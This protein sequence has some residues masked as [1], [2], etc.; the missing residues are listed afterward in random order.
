MALLAHLTAST[1]SLAVKRAF[2]TAICIYR[3]RE[4]GREVRRGRGRER[5]IGKDIGREERS[6]FEHI[7][8]HAHAHL[9]LRERE[10]ERVRVLVL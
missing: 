9:H 5:D 10:G 6:R 7:H 2:A 1:T 4:G 3:V 8:A